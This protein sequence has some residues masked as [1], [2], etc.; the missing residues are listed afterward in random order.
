MKVRRAILVGTTAFVTLLAPV[1]SASSQQPVKQHAQITVQAH[2]HYCPRFA[3]NQ[4]HRLSDGGCKFGPVDKLI[5][6]RVPEG[7]RAIYWN[8]STVRKARSGQRIKTSEAT[9]YRNGS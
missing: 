8:G 5:R 9:F 6:G 2:G 3:G 7:W 1:A 4:T